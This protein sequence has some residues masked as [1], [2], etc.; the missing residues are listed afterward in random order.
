MELD[1]TVMSEAELA[2]LAEWVALVK[3]TRALVRAG[4]T[5]RGD[6]PDP[7]L[8]VHG[9]VAPDGGEALFALVAMQTGATQ[10]PGLVRLPGLDPD[11]TYRLTLEPPGHRLTPT[12]VLPPW[13]VAAAPGGPG[14]VLPG[15]VLGR[16]GIQAPQLHPATLVLLHLEAV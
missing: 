14:V 11:R 7:A 13:A 6:H 16:H 12:R 1:L 4:R 10:P 5:V 9:V 8:W 3:R 2:E 15:R